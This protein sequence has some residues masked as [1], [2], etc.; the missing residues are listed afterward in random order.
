M[1]FSATYAHQADT[2]WLTFP[3]D[4]NYQAFGAGFQAPQYRKIGDLVY[5][6]G[7][8]TRNTSS[9]AAGSRAGTLAAGFRPPAITIFEQ[10]GGGTRARV[11]VEADGEIRHQD[12]ILTVGG[13]LSFD[14]IVF[15]TV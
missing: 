5:L 11:D 8:I 3:F 13:F 10:G 15:S 2:G 14:G 9:A 6:R 1:T 7:T 12:L 4:A